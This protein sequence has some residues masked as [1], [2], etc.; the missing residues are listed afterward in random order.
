MPE[1]I[2]NLS[3]GGAYNSG[4]NIK[5]RVSTVQNRDMSFM[6]F[7]DA[8]WQFIHSLV[9]ALFAAAFVSVADPSPRR[10]YDWSMEKVE[11]L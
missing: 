3:V 7:H 8:R 4:Y 6:F 9:H 2:N 1:S 10:F 11:R 5:I